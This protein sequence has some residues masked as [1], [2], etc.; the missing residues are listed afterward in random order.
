MTTLEHRRPVTQ[1]FAR[2]RLR[3][4]ARAG[5]AR[6]DH[7]QGGGAR[8]D[9]A[10][11]AGRHRDQ[12]RRRGVSD[13]RDQAIVAT[14]DFFMP[15]VDD[16][17]DFGAIAATNAISDVYAMGGTP[18][19][20]AGAGGDA[21]RQA[22]GRDDPAD[23]RRRRVGL[24]ASRHSRSPAATASIRSSRSTG[25][26]P[27]ASSIPATSSATRTAKPGDKIV[28][29]KALGVG[30][31]GAALKKQQ[32]TEAQ[33]REL[34]ASTTQLNTPGIA[35]GAASR[36]A[37]ADRCHRL[38]AA[39]PPAGSLPG[40]RRSRDACAG[41]PCRCSPRRATLA[42]GRTR[43]RRL[44]PQLE[45]IR[46]PRRSDAATS[47]RAGSLTDPQTSGGLLVACAPE[48]VDEVLATFRAEGFRARRGDRRDRER[49]RP[50]CRSSELRRG[51]QNMCCGSRSK[52]S[53]QART[54]EVD[55]P[56]RHLASDGARWRSRPTSADR[57][58]GLRRRA[59]RRPRARPRA[60][61]RCG[62]AGRSR[63]GC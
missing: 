22:A 11:T 59:G 26:W 27:S 39:G 61:W 47:G 19:L 56:A 5:G 2:R 42:G 46:R 36:R 21:D 60:S 54:A 24:P 16:P 37:R 8:P 6:A 1:P 12:R 52:V 9:P 57:I 14:T 50:A 41:A 30:V 7:R 53:L 48:A 18:A 33:Y 31:Y 20:R 58:D 15:I 29:G 23:S 44:G 55:R 17:F 34:I 62:G 4:Q 40:L 51:Q 3:L 10:R 49:A 28:L 32:I 43:H 38:R 25:S 13:Q 63:P 45:G 35:A